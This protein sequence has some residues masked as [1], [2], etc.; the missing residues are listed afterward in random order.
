MTSSE[1]DPARSEQRPAIQVPSGR[2]DAKDSHSVYAKVWSALAASSNSGEVLDRDGLLIISAGGKWPIMNT[3]FLSSPVESNAD[4]QNRI[5]IAKEYFGQ[6]E[7]LWLFISFNAW[8]N[9]NIDAEQLFS[10]NRVAYL[11]RCVGMQAERLLPARKGISELLYRRVESESERLEFADINADSYGFPPEWRND[12]LPRK[13][14]QRSGQLGG[15]AVGRRYGCLGIRGYTTEPAEK[16]V[17]RGYRVP[18]RSF[19]VRIW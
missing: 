1:I 12:A 2:N 6:K 17:R 8:I 9:D 15:G 13:R 3:A 18:L 14:G 4:L 11:E 19:A 7:R 5:S 10:D 16:P